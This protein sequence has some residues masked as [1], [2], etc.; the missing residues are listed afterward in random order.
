[1]RLKSEKLFLFDDFVD[2]YFAYM[3]RIGLRKNN[4]RR[5]YW[6]NNSQHF[7][8][9]AFRG[10]RSFEFYQLQKEQVEIQYLPQIKHLFFEE[11]ILERKV[12]FL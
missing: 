4:C 3:D 5:P 7:R 10:K 12:F 11:T 8:S 1:V 9:C 2:G 6:H